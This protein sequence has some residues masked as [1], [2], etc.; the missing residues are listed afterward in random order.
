MKPFINTWVLIAIVL[1]GCDLTKTRNQDNTIDERIKSELATGER[2]DTI[3]LDIVLGETETQVASKLKALQRSGKLQLDASRQYEYL[4][5]FDSPILETAT[6]N[7]STDFFENGL[8]KLTLVVKPAGLS[9]SEDLLKV[10]LVKLY[11]S[12]YGYRFLEENS[13]IS[14]YNDYVLIKGNL[15]IEIL[16]AIDGVR[17]IYTDLIAEQAKKEQEKFETKEEERSTIEDL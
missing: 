14:E 13:I 7:M 8:Y 10:Q 9:T 1:T 17:V 2:N 4:F 5:N 12:K 6:A 16:T 11:G 3:F 15:M